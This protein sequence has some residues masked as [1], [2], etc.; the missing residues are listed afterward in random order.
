MPTTLKEK[1]LPPSEPHGK[2][3][4]RSTCVW[5]C[6]VAILTLVASGLGL[7]FVI[8]KVI[9]GLA[10]QRALY[11]KRHEHI[12]SA[13]VSPLIGP[14][15]TFDLA[16]S[17]WLRTDEESMTDEIM[18]FQGDSKKPGFFFPL[19]PTIP[20]FS[21]IVFR[22]LSLKDKNIFATV[23]FTLPTAYFR[24]HFL[25]DNDLRGSVVLIP[26]SPSPL[27]QIMEYSTWIP[28]FIPVF[29]VRSW[30]FPLGSSDVKN[31]TTADKAVE[32]FGITVPLL[33]FHNIRQRCHNVE[34]DFVY[35]EEEGVSSTTEFKSPLTH[36]PYIVTRTQI[37]IMDE[38]SLFD[39]RAYLEKHRI[40]KQISCQ[41]QRTLFPSIYE[42][43]RS[44]I[45]VGHVETAMTLQ[46]RDEGGPFDIVYSPY[47]S[48]SQTSG[49]KDLL[50]IPVHREACSTIEDSVQAAKD[51]LETIEVSWNLAFSGRS[52]PKFAFL[53]EMEK[54][55]VPT[56]FDMEL[57]E[58]HR[59]LAHDEIE[60][61]DGVWGH[62]HHENS[63]PRRRYL[64]T[65]LELKFATMIIIFDARY[66]YT[67]KTTVAISTI[68]TL[69]L[70]GSNAI[71]AIAPDI[72]VAMIHSEGASD[73][74]STL[75]NIT[76]SL[77][78]AFLM[79]RAVFRLTGNDSGQ[80]NSRRWIPRQAPLSHA[81]RASRRVENR[82]SYWT[83]GAVSTLSLEL[84]LIR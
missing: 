26:T 76:M 45:D 48:L 29:S 32:S 52:Y 38:T 37:R 43:D 19:P 70:A 36:H 27:D 25:T 44:Y 56:R 54:H 42:C 66:W 2:P 62:R 69:L 57:S 11:Y 46:T 30:P 6:V 16:V 58:H 3:R 41:Q 80:S 18:A 73:W 22:G 61:N 79:M 49:P 14:E 15:Q 35:D 24:N 40:L 4:S 50:P 20:L 82:L 67:R 84:I 71:N 28:D 12:R 77:F 51:D 53:E 64:L 23:N 8:P 10:V 31:K 68:G 39:R 9:N 75:F 1:S 63:H 17:V 72:A 47:M 81:E 7:A 13:V 78:P 55:N 60:L 83:K 34:D 65:A 21:D 59:V 33:Q 5:L 74:F